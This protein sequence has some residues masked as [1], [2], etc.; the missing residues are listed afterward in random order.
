MSDNTVNNS[1]DT[2]FTA[3]TRSNKLLFCFVLQFR[4]NSD[5]CRTA[6][7]VGV[8]GMGMGHSCASVTEDM[9]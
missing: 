8:S 9:N 5:V 6:A 3:N 7:A 4:H 2:D 1:V